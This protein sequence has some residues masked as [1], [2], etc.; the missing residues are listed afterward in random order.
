MFGVE[1]DWV[2]NS[3]SMELYSYTLPCA[4]IFVM[5]Q[6]QKL[7]A[8]FHFAVLADRKMFVGK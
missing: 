5:F 8:E 3:M 4:Y 2:V 6:H 7:L 1:V